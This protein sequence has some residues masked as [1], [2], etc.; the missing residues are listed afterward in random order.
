M[1]KEYG[2]WH[3]VEKP[4]CLYYTILTEL[5][6]CIILKIIKIGLKENE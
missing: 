2:V 1:A 4:V 3:K 6:N 5:L